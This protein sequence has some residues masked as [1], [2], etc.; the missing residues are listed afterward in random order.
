MI[1]LP[2]QFP[3]LPPEGYSYYVEQFNTRLLRIMLLCHCEF[4]YN[5]GKPT[6]TVWGFYNSKKNTY[7][8]PINSKTVGDVVNID[9]TRNYTA[10]PLK[11]VGVEKYFV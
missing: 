3:H 5:Q 7:Y 6:A 9:D 1:E 8:S 4:A 10:M 11:K 2:A